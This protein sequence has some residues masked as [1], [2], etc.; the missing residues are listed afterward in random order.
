MYFVYQYCY[1]ASIPNTNESKVIICFMSM[2][3]F[4]PLLRR[5]GTYS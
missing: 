2:P 4:L 1:S 3:W 5:C